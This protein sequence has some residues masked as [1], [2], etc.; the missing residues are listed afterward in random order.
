MNDIIESTGSK[1]CD[2]VKKAAEDRK[3]KK[4]I[5]LSKIINE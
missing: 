1:T 5:N 4:T 2:M 3:R